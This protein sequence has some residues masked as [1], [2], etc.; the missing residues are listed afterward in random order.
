MFLTVFWKLKE[1]KKV[2]G[3]S[4]WQSRN[5]GD[6]KM[7]LQWCETC[8]LMLLCPRSEDTIFPVLLMKCVMGREKS[9]WLGIFRTTIK[10]WKNTVCLGNKGVLQRLLHV[11][12]PQV[13]NIVYMGVNHRFFKSRNMS[14]WEPVCRSVCA[15]ARA[16]T[17]FLE[18]L[19]VWALC[20]W[21][22]TLP[23]AATAPPSS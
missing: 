15:V 4:I 7:V 21:A 13:N 3:N 22:K 1:C 14:V 8:H 18:S 23:P 12:S 10:H 17:L 11:K 5:L 6:G 2:V 19:V 20:T 9:L 16:Q